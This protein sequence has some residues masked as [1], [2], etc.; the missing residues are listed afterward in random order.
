MTLTLEI[1]LSDLNVVDHVLGG[2]IFDIGELFFLF[3]PA[4]TLAE[5]ICMPGTNSQK[6]ASC[7]IKE[8]R[9]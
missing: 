6:S 4:P 5:W 1:S 2:N 7:T 3:F 9:H 8:K